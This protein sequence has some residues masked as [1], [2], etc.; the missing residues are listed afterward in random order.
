MQLS[1]LGFEVEKQVDLE[2]DWDRIAAHVQRLV[3]MMRRIAGY[4]IERE[5]P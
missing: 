5:T 2:S 4:P 1:R 3:G